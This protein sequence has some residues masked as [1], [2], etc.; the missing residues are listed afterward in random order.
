MQAAKGD[1]PRERELGLW[2]IID[3]DDILVGNVL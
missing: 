2:Y 1:N 3:I